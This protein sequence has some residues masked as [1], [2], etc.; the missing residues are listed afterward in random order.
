MNCMRERE[1]ERDVLSPCSLSLSIIEISLLP[2]YW[3]QKDCIWR[4]TNGS[5]VNLN[6]VRFRNDDAL[7]S[8][9]CRMDVISCSFMNQ[10]HGVT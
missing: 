6:K 8:H 10:S 2:C 5:T 3:H 4:R 1:R 7:V 9:N